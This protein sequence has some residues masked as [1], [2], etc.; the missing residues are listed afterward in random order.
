MTAEISMIKLRYWIISIYLLISF[1]GFLIL[2]IYILNQSQS[3]SAN[4]SLVLSI[5]GTAWIALS[6]FGIYLSSLMI[7]SI[8]GFIISK[9]LNKNEAKIAFRFLSY[10]MVS[11]FVVFVIYWLIN[12]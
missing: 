10:L 1:V 5:I 4:N 12:S 3:I 8:L 9:R 2:R 6:S 11:F 7:I